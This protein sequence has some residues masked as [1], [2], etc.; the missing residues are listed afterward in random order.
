MN[1]V[2][3]PV[4]GV[5]MVPD[6]RVSTVSARQGTA[7]C[8][9]MRE[10]IS[11]AVSLRGWAAAVAAAVRRMAAR[12]VMLF[13]GLDADV[14]EGDELFGLALEADEAFG[15]FRIVGVEDGFAVQFDQEVVAFGGDVEVVPLV[16]LDLGRGRGFDGANQG[17]G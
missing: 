5:S 10:M 8:F 14:A 3:M 16:G 15:V 2:A 12:R 11:P 1:V 13:D 4:T 9:W 17:S 6:L 7:T